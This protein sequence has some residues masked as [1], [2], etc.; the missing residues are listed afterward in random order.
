L[1]EETGRAEDMGRFRAPSLRNVAL[2]APYMHDGSVATLPEVL[3]LY[4]AGGR[5][6]TTGPLAGDGRRSP[7]KSPLVDLIRLNT[8]EQAD[9]LAFLQA[10]TDTAFVSNP[11]LGAPTR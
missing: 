5:S 3:A 6:V 1:I 8:A 10:L 9:L 2:T 4:A 11:A 7:L